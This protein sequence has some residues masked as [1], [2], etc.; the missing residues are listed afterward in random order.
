MGELSIA[1]GHGASVWLFA[2]MQPLVRFEV[3]LLFEALVANFANEATNVVVDEHV[4]GQQSLGTENLVTNVA[5]HVG[6]SR[7]QRFPAFGF[8]RF[9]ILLFLHRQIRVVVTI[10]PKSTCLY[11]DAHLFSRLRR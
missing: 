4:L 5:S 8:V 3:S 9:A 6:P 11:P 10:R 2:R 7:R 1:V